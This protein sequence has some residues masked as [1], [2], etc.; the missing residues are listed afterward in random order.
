M[1][2]IPFNDALARQAVNENIPDNKKRLIAPVK[3]RNTLNRML[4]VQRETLLEMQDVV[5]SVSMAD[6]IGTVNASTGMAFVT[7]AEEE[8]LL[9]SSADQ[10]SG[11]YFDVVVAGTMNIFNTAGTP[12][13]VSVGD[14]IIS[15]G[16]KWD[17]LPAG[18]LALTLAMQAEYN[19]QIIEIITGVFTGE[20]LAGGI[21]D[22]AAGSFSTPPSI[23]G[24]GTNIG[25]STNINTR[26]TWKVGNTVKF[27]LYVKESVPGSTIS[28]RPRFQLGV[29]RLGTLNPN[30][31]SGTIRRVNSD[32]IELT[33][34]YTIL[35]GDEG[36][37]FSMM[38]TIPST[39]PTGTVRTWTW[40]RLK[41]SVSSVSGDYNALS[42]K[43]AFIDSKMLSIDD[44]T[45]ENTVLPDG[46]DG[47][48]LNG[49]NGS[50]SNRITIPIGQSGHGSYIR[51]MLPMKNFKNWL[52]LIGIPVS[53]TC[54]IVKSANWAKPFSVFAD[55]VR[56]GAL[57]ESV[58]MTNK[59]ITS[60]SNSI[61][62]VK[63]TYIP[64]QGDTLFK[65]FIQ[66]QT[67]ST[68][69]ASN[70]SYFEVYDFTYSHDIPLGFSTKNAYIFAKNNEFLENKIKN[71]ESGGTLTTLKVN[72][73]GSGD[74]ASI[75]LAIDSINLYYQS[76]EATENHWFEIVVAPGST[77][78]DINWT[79]PPYTA[80]RASAGGK[81]HIKGFGPVNSSDGFIAGNSTFWMKGTAE[82]DGFDVTAENLR[83]PIHD[84][85]QGIN[86]DTVHRY[87]NLRVLHL[88]NESANDY[89]KANS[90]PLVGWTSIKPFGFGAASGQKVFLENV[91]FLSKVE[92][93]Y[94]HNNK[95]FQRPCL[96]QMD[97][98]SIAKE[99]FGANTVVQS[100]GSGTKD[101]L[102]VNGA[103][104]SLGYIAH[105]D[106]P[107]WKTTDPNKQYADHTEIQIFISGLKQPLGYLSSLRGRALKIESGDGSFTAA[108]T[109]RVSGSASDA[110]FGVSGRYIQKDLG[111]G[112]A[113]YVS[114]YWD[115]SGIGVGDI[116]TTQV[117]NTIGRRLGDCSSV[118]KRLSVSINGA[119]PVNIDFSSDMRTVSNEDIILTINGVLKTVATAS[120]Y[121]VSKYEYYPEM[122]GFQNTFFNNSSTVTIPAWSPL[123]YD[124][125]GGFTVKTSVKVVELSDLAS[126]FIGFNP[127]PIPPKSLGRVLTRGVLHRSTQARG[128][129]PVVN[130]QAISLSATVAGNLQTNTVANKV[131]GRG[132]S[133]D[134]FE[135]T[136][137]I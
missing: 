18:S 63:F 81:S 13:S 77:I 12:V 92:A 47:R 3:V 61:S 75:P 64:Q 126:S 118:S 71:L 42:E 101:I 45:I 34:S 50:N 16:T 44:K 67:G 53:F 2:E 96:L 57:V 105:N 99:T 80:I 14:R 32:E 137:N 52:D 43:M 10:E 28:N 109:V 31:A 11:K 83:Y 119:A 108:N 5:N 23:S 59:S 107:Y 27:Q 117:N 85:D 51:P 76:N 37:R 40:L 73:D 35:T 33:I 39:N 79:I 95:D 19:S 86:V 25:I 49:A 87:R 15:R 56:N 125:E 127:F 88:G 123:K 70:E 66:V 94:I 6:G 1:V 84:E 129:S 91:N 36:F 72:P 7:E 111:Y 9:T 106:S 121:D 122:N 112:V 41:S 128:L 30:V 78:L 58:G 110:I 21:I 82:I 17:R 97:G 54:R 60:L 4:D 62:I 133:V 29:T 134:W 100:I 55:V 102:R 131:I 90:L 135:F 115:I 68:G 24:V 89:R 20:A 8:Y 93:L 103:D 22:L 132:V 136:G 69:I 38:T 46:Y 114:S 116:G 104:T 74:F 98:G 113:S 48:A 65:P 120:I 130:G 26:G 124:S